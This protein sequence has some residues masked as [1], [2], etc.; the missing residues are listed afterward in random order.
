MAGVSVNGSAG[1]P[2][3]SLA[4]SLESS[5]VVVPDGRKVMIPAIPH[6][7]DPSLQAYGF[8]LTDSVLPV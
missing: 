5:G 6:M 7:A 8:M 4:P 3:D 2:Q 1:F